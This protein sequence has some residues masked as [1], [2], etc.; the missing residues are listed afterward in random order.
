MNIESNKE[1]TQTKNG[2]FNLE[3][4]TFTILY[5]IGNI[6]NYIIFNNILIFFFN[7]KNYI[8]QKN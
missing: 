6:F 1:V 8:S 4:K 3:I 5:Y 2:Y 7:I